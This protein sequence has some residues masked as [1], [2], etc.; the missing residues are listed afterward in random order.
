MPCR[1]ND[2]R[3]SGLDAG[4]P[5]GNL[6]D[7]P[8]DRRGPWAAPEG[9]RLRHDVRPRGGVRRRGTGTQR[10]KTEF[11]RI[12][13]C[14]AASPPGD[15]IG[16]SRKGA[17]IHAHTIGS[18]P[19]RVSLV[20]GCHADEPAGPRFLHRLLRYLASEDGSALRRAATWSIIPHINPDGASANAAWQIPGAPH[21]DIGAYLRH[22]VRELPGD[23]IEFGF[24]RRESDWGARPENRAAWEFWRAGAPYDLHVS[25]HGMGVAAG[26]Y[27]LV[28]RS[29][30]PRFGDAAA[31][32][33][34]EAE[35]GG[36]TLHDV[37]RHGEKGFHRLARGF[38]S[39]PDSRSM[40]RH[41]VALDDPATAGRFRP[42]SMEAVRK[43]SGDTLT[44][45]TEM[46]L[47]ITPGVG[48]EL[49]PPDPVLTRWRERIAEWDARFRGARGEDDEARVEA[50]V[51][52]EAEA[53]GLTAM[54]VRD[55]M[56]F[57]WAFIR[58]GLKV[59]GAAR[60]EVG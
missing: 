14:V 11:A 59:A 33:A 51:R 27:F 34:H 57:Q 49:G 29:W 40:K 23:D 12:V 53:A 54:P 26:P 8:D 45:V 43:L 22:R 18:G 38:C 39:R 24:P 36:Y 35:T 4:R 7:R 21:Y 9:Y 6:P 46:P 56:R 28:E 13:S 32:L 25:I 44:L 5:L 30:W 19:L 20:A 58:A 47:F 1:R 41:F 60:A 50:A 17:P 42:S 3:R 37:E 15:V 16:C 10:V 48:E 55:Q 2:H 52:D 31:S